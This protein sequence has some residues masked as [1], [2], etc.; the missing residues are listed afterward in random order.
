MAADV[1]VDMTAAQ[2]GE[3]VAERSRA[4]C[5]DHEGGAGLQAAMSAALR[6]ALLA[7]VFVALRWRKLTAQN[8]PTREEIAVYAGLH[9]AAA[10]GDVA[11]I[12]KLVKDGEKLNIQ[13]AKSR[14]PLHRR[15]VHEAARM[16]PARYSSSGRIRMR[17]TSSATTSLPSRPSPTTS[18]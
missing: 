14:T 17:S 18:R 7:A 6:L 15:R 2:F 5:R 12:E 4:H 9:E 16:R 10:K 13:D 1:R 11:E 8:A 3:F